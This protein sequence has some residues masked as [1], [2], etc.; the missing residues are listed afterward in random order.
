M[1]ERTLM[2]DQP[3]PSSYNDIRNNRRNNLVTSALGS[4]KKHLI[5]TEVLVLI[6]TTI[7]LPAPEKTGYRA[8]K[9]NRNFRSQSASKNVFEVVG[10]TT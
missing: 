4:V 8:H 10:T 9:M 2:K 6:A 1:N 5:L 3:W 7:V